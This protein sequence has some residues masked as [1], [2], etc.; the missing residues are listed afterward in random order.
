VTLMR[1]PTCVGSCSLFAASMTSIEAAFFFRKPDL[2]LRDFGAS[3]PAV[4]FSRNLSSSCSRHPVTVMAAWS[5]TGV[6][7]ADS[8]LGAV[9]ADST[10]GALD[11]DSTAGTPAPAVAFA[12]VASDLALVAGTALAGRVLDAAVLLAWARGAGACCGVGS[13]VAASCT[14]SSNAVTSGCDGWRA[15]TITAAAAEIT[16]ATARARDRG[17][18]ST[19]AIFFPGISPP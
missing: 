15:I 1:W 12:V 16:T 3:T 18:L 9:V 10:A 8:T 13:T 11:T 6:L 19:Y 17:V 5:C 7:E 2:Q 14:C 4:S